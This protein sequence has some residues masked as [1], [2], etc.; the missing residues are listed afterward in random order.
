[1][2]FT[3]LAFFA[4]SCNTII[5]APVDAAAK[6]IAATSNVAAAADVN[7]AADT[8]AAKD[9]GILDRS[10]KDVIESMDDLVAGLRSFDRVV[11]RGGDSNKAAD[12]VQRYSEDVV[13]TLKDGTAQVKTIAALYTY[14]S[15]NMVPTV[16]SLTDHVQ[17]AT[18]AWI[19]AK[20]SV[21]RT[22]GKEMAQMILEKQAAASEE[23]SAAIISKMPFMAVSA[24]R[25]YSTKS[26]T[27]IAQAIQ[28]YAW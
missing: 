17:T 3:Q 19:A 20:S 24:A 8:A 5:A 26:K 7:A 18:N 23:F 4:L 27:S 21:D 22:G 12:D 16:Q 25:R 14:E 2:R 15:M 6:N 9:T 11:K 28:A 13:S 10:I 1:M